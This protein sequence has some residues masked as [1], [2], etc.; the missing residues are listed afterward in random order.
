M[1][2][3]PSSGEAPSATGDVVK[4]ASDGFARR[5]L[6]RRLMDVVALPA[7]RGNMQDRAIAGD[8]LLEILMD[9]DVAA[10]EL[11]ARRLQEMS[12]APKRLLRFLALDVPHVAQ[13]ILSENRAFDDADLCYIVAHG[14]TPHRVACAR[15]RDIGPAVATAIAET[16]DAI[17]MKALLDNN[18]SRLSERSVELMV[19]ASRNAPALPPLL[20][21]REEVRPAHALAMFWWSAAAERRQILIRFSAERTL[22]IEMCADI[23]RY[24][25]TDIDP[26]VRKA[27]QV[28]ERRQRDRSAIDRS[29]HE[30][31]EAAIMDAAARG[32]TP[33]AMADISALSGIKA[34]TGERIFQDIGGEGIAVLC[35]ATG[36][37]RDYLRA[38]WKATGAPDDGPDFIRVSEVYETIAVAKAQ[39]VLRYWNWSLSSAFSPDAIVTDDDADDAGFA[40]ELRLIDAGRPRTAYGR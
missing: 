17:A 37:K 38:L 13:L 32:M 15:R 7:S 26:V 19:S 21:Q 27:L 36:L 1:S 39:T 8:L 23:F 35:K 40:R 12:Q 29:P 11:C 5:S 6:L 24:S 20:I 10:R 25:A 30:S 28:I 22:L 2:N 16:G 34:S 9:S 31:L 3:V 18:Q 33:A 4:T 14:S